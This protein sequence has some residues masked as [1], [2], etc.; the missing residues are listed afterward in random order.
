[1]LFAR[2]HVAHDDARQAV[3]ALEPDEPVL[4]AIDAE[5]QPA[6]PVRDEIAPVFAR[7]D[8]RSAR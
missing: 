5:D 6:G 7:R 3:L 2:A 4:S 8:R 1:M